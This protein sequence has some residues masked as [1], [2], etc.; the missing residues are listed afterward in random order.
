M[1]FIRP[2]KPIDNAFI[3][4]FN[5][6]FREQCLNDNW[7]MSLA[8]AKDIIENW[9]IKY[10]SVRPHSSLGGITPEMFF[11]NFEKKLHLTVV[12]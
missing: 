10:N 9:R 8:H 1:N 3:E 7:F 5:G 2:G 11:N 12:Q 4:S 6:T